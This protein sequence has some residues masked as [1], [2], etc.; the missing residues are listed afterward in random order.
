MPIDLMPFVDAYQDESGENDRFIFRFV[1]AKNVFAVVKRFHGR[2]RPATLK[3][4]DMRDGGTLEAT[5]SHWST[6]KVFTPSDAE[7]RATQ[8]YAARLLRCVLVRHEERM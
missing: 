1:E 2:G 6:N 4:W 5:I 3:L 7:T 8:Q